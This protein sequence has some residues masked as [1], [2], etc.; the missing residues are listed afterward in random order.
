MFKVKR[1]NES[2]FGQKPIDKNKGNF[3][4]AQGIVPS[5]SSMKETGGFLCQYCARVRAPFHVNCFK[6][7]ISNAMR[8]LINNTQ[9]NIIGDFM[10]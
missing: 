10:R 4:R 2:I 8:V 9:E 1:M 5:S 7:T 6:R 3:T